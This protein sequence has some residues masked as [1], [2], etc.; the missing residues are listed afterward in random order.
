MGLMKWLNDRLWKW[1]AKKDNK[2]SES[3]LLCEGTLELTDISYGKHG[4]FNTLDIYLPNDYKGRLPVIINAHG[5][6]YCYGDK[7]HNKAYCSS[8]AKHGYIVVNANYRLVQDAKYPAQIQDLFTVFN[9]IEKNTLEYP[10]DL[11]NVF[12]SGS[13]AGAHLIGLSACILNNPKLQ[14]KFKVSSK[15]K[16]KAINF[17][18]GVFEF[19]KFKN[20]PLLRDYQE[21]IF[22]KHYSKHEFYHYSSVYEL[23]DNNF[24][25]VSIISTKFDP[26]KFYSKRMIKELEKHQIP[27]SSIYLQDHKNFGHVFNIN[28]PLADPVCKMVNYNTLHFFNKYT[29]HPNPLLT[30]KDKLW[31]LE[32]Y[33]TESMGALLNKDNKEII[34]STP[35]VQNITLDI[36]EQP[37]ILK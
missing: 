8:L 30:N 25:P 17:S 18:C 29:T 15:L 31:Y 5:G 34:L 26:L 22:G 27:Y 2:L 35:E 28:Y 37:E 24:P 13:S 23:M 7:S 14:E 1:S 11:D 20:L 6:G 10:F 33:K 4:E 12:L 36:V 16:I 19:M 32:K 3:R 9:F 21:I